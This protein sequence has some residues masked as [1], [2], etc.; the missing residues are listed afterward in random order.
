M[1]NRMQQGIRRVMRRKEDQ[2]IISFVVI[3]YDMPLQAQNTVRSLLPDY[4]RDTFADEYE[5]VIVENASANTISRDFLKTLPDNF[6]YHLRNETHP[7]PVYAID[8]GIEQSQGKNICVM[9]DGARLVTPG[10][11]NNMIRG[12][13]LARHVLVTVPGYHLG[14]ELQQK[15]V[16]SGYDADQ[17]QILMESI[18]WPDNGYR[19][20][21]IACFSGSCAQGFYLSHSESNCISMPRRVWADLGGYDAKFDMRGGGLVN[22]DLYKRACKYP[23]MTHV[24]LQGEGTFHQFH[25]GVTTGGD[26]AQERQAFIDAIKAQYEEI[27]GQKF[28]APET[29]PIYLGKLSNEVLPYVQFSATRKL[30]RLKKDV[31]K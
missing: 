9:I 30:D 14:F 26:E 11:V 5:V 6:S 2:F 31:S 24:L 20:F 21:E 12:H 15:S 29:D 22:L 1:L 8:Y 16:G 25:G 4:Q 10:V 3:V 17:E 19:L 7:T 28:S 23:E 27:R 18:A 13:R